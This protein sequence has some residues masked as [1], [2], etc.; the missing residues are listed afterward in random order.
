MKKPILYI[1]NM[2]AQK[3]A[4]VTSIETLGILLEKEGFHVIRSSSLNNKF[5]R[6][7]DMLRS[8]L[9]HKRRVSVV[10]IDTYSTQ[11]FWYAY[12]VS[13]LCVLLGI[14]Y[15][16]I[17]RGG[18]LPNRLTNNRVV[19]Q[20]IFR[21]AKVN[22]APSHYLLDEFGKKGI[23][24]LTY[25]PNSIE[26]T[27]YPFFYR[28]VIT[29]KLLWVRSFADIYNPLL[30]IQVLEQLLPSYPEAELCMVGPEKD[31]AMKRC[32]SYANEK[33]LP[34][35][36]TGKLSKEEWIG[37]SKNYDLFINTTNFDNTPVSVMEA[38]A[39]GLPIVSTEV[40]GI[41]FLLED[42]KDALLVPP[43]NVN[44]FVNA[45]RSLLQNPEKARE[46]SIQARSKVE[47][48]DWKVV[49]EAWLNLLD[50]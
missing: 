11:N 46:L 31:G 44:A 28:K 39:L 26:L 1:G 20:N 9:I 47:K 30:A 4:T 42:Q 35:T 33:K 34:V 49:R 18:N 40:G 7:A 24:N 8:T 15:I 19:S 43:N 16:P 2:L 17:L 25:I 50:D 29:P 36:F 27:N 12:L 5:L 32:K 6:L 48:F 41:P 22:V 45:L 3:G 10:L 21:G 38:M 37:L 14:P 23:M 13:Q